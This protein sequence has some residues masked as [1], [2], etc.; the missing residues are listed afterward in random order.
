MGKT[1]SNLNK[2]VLGASE[3]EVNSSLDSLGCFLLFKYP[4]GEEELI[5][6]TVELPGVA[7]QGGKGWNTIS[8]SH[9]RELWWEL[10][11]M[12]IHVKILPRPKPRLFFA[13]PGSPGQAH[14]HSSTRSGIHYV[15]SKYKLKGIHL[16]NVLPWNRAFWGNFILNSVTISCFPNA[17]FYFL[18]GVWSNLPW[19]AHVL[20]FSLEFKLTLYNP[21]LKGSF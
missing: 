12:V 5:M 17:A 3:R 4:S 10:H 21:G 19:H 18:M 11:C 15:V 7:F 1:H 9:G 14:S 2:K 20:P 6:G 8:L 16:F 13:L